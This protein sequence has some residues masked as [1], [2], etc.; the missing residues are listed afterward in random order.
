MLSCK[1]ERFAKELTRLRLEQKFLD[2]ERSR[3][4]RREPD[5][6]AKGL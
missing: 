4:G 2:L 3:F 1:D 5:K 6:L